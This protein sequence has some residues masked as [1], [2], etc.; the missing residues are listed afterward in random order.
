MALDCIYQILQPLIILCSREIIRLGAHWFLC[1]FQV[2]LLTNV[3]PH[4]H[5]FTI[6]IIPPHWHDTGS[7]NP[8]L[9]MTRTHLVYSQYHGCW[10]P[11][12]KRSL[13][14]SNNMTPSS[15][16][17]IFR[18]TGH[19]CRE[20]TDPAWIPHTKA[21]DVELRCFPWFASELTV[22]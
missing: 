1:Y 13:G 7:W 19:L 8:P 18:I 17:N 11:G 21:S 6:S 20:F 15:N 16:E 10:C 12:D 9:C 5:V 22:E 2:Y 14:I 3:A 4:K